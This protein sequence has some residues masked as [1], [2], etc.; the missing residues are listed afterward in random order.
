MEN[1][2]K[3]QILDRKFQKVFRHLRLSEAR[4][5]ERINDFQILIENLLDGCRLSSSEN[6]LCITRHTHNDTKKSRA[7]IGI[8]ISASSA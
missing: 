2:R 8:G 5:C 3:I 6:V 1:I 4:R 7:R